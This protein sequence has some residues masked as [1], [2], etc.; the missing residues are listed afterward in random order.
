LKLS[1]DKIKGKNQKNGKFFKHNDF[2]F[3][4]LFFNLILT[5]TSI[6]PRQCGCVITP[7]LLAIMQ[8]Y[9]KKII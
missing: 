1:E 7:V 9:G 2:T 3:F 5:P 8:K 4:H 6:L